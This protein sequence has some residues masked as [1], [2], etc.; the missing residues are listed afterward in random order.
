MSPSM[1][2]RL[3]AIAS[4]A[5]AS[6]LTAGAAGPA[7]AANNAEQVVFSGI[8]L[9]PASSEPFGFWIWCQNAQ[10]PSSRGRY[11]TDCNG[12]VYFYARGIVAHVTGEI[13]EPDE[14]LYE[15]EIESDDGRVSCTLDNVPPINRGPNNTVTAACLVD[16]QL[17]TDLMSTDAVVVSTGP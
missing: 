16:G 10:A 7:A 6:I 4:L 15:M 17:V 14:G 1:S 2:R 9:P 3:A 12:A 5:A 11:E 8:G 13:T